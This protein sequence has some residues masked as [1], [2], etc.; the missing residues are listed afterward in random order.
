MPRLRAAPP[1]QGQRRAM[2]EK[3]GGSPDTI[4]AGAAGREFDGKGN[5][6]KPAAK[7]CN[8][9]SVA[10]AQFGLVAARRSPFHEELHRGRSKRLSGRR[11]IVKRAIEWRKQMHALA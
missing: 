11:H 10:V 6:V 4:C 7:S 8:N 5:P 9:R 2:V 3:V 1:L